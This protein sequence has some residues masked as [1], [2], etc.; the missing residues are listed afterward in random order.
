MMSGHRKTAKKKC[1]Q[2]F[3]GFTSTSVFIEVSLPQR[4]RAYMQYVAKTI[5]RQNVVMR[6]NRVL[7]TSLSPSKTIGTPTFP[8][9]TLLCIFYL[10]NRARNEM[11]NL[12]FTD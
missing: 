6:D 3:F 4:M 8:R 12:I 1:E 10:Q 2:L 11:A 5:P 7:K 9:L